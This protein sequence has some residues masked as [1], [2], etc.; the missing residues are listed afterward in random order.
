MVRQV[1]G[2]TLIEVVIAMAIL[3]VLTAVAIPGYSVWLP[4][5]RFYPGPDE[6]EPAQESVES[7]SQKGEG[8]QGL[9]LL[10]CYC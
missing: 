10:C 6:A 5:Y 2:F 8:R 9:V 7:K 3:A 4:N 1:Q